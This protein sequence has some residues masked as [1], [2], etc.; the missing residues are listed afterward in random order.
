MSDR[1]T[2]RQYVIKY[3]STY[4]LLTS[5]GLRLFSSTKIILAASRGL[6]DLV[7]SRASPFFSCHFRSV[8]KGPPSHANPNVAR[9]S[10]VTHR[11]SVGLAYL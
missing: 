4:P 11:S 6:H 5:A 10:N 1:L 9:E 7:N 8:A 2:F 3:D